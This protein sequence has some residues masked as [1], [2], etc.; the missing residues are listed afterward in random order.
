MNIKLILFLFVSLVFLSGKT[1][2]TGTALS[3]GIQ[4]SPNQLTL[5]SKIGYQDKLTVLNPT[6]DV[7]IFEV[8]SDNFQDAFNISPKSF[9]L[10]SGSSRQVLI[11]AQ[12]KSNFQGST[13]STNISVVGKPLALGTE[14]EIASGV[15]IPV[16]VNFE[17]HNNNPNIKT[18]LGLG[19]LL[20]FMVFA[21]WQKRKNK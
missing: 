14:I 13:L 18:L 11:S 15:K 4:V 12:K 20:C 7:Q 8:Y 3:S 5:D 19:L 9:T 17:T 2:F 16:T 10:E 1:P 21:V 6:A